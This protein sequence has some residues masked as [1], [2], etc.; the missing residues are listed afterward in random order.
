M[1]TVLKPCKLERDVRPSPESEE[2][3]KEKTLE[4]PEAVEA[5]QLSQNVAKRDA[6][7]EEPDYEYEYEE[8]NREESQS[9]KRQPNGQEPEKSEAAGAEVEERAGQKE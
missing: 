6:L 5:E 7:E 2:P 9:E 8:P 1:Q 4:D 3:T